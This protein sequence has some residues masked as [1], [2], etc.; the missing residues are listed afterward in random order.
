MVMCVWRKRRG[1]GGG[2]AGGGVRRRDVEIHV[3]AETKREQPWKSPTFQ[4]NIS[5]DVSVD[6]ATDSVLRPDKRVGSL[7]LKLLLHGLDI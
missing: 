6:I 5:F 2:D 1:G 3:P 4:Y 7:V